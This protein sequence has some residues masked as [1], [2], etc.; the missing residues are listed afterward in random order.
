LI[1]FGAVKQVSVPNGDPETGL[2]NLTI[3]IGTQG[4]MANEQ[5][6]GKPKFCSDV[7]AVGVLAVQVLTG[8]HP[9]HWHED[10]N[11]E[12]A[13]H[14]QV[15]QIDPEFQAVLDRMIR[16]DFR[17][18]YIDAA[19]ALAALEALPE[20]TPDPEPDYGLLPETIRLN[21]SSNTAPQSATTPQTNTETSLSG[22][23][24]KANIE[25]SNGREVISSDE[26]PISTAIWVPNDSLIHALQNDKSGLTQ[27]VGRPLL[28]DSNS[29]SSG[30]PTGSSRYQTR[31]WFI[32]G[33]LLAAGL[34]VGLSQILFPQF[35]IQIGQNS[36][37]PNFT[38]HSTASPTPVLDPEQQAVLVLGEANHLLQTKQYDKALKAYARAIE[39]KSN[40]AEAYAGRCEAL[41]QLNRPEEAIVSCND[42]LDLKPNY[43]EALWSQGNVRLLQNRPYEALK[44]YEQVT[45][46]KPEF[47]AGWVK[48]GVALQRLGRSAEALDALDQGIDLERNSFE[49]WI[50]KGEALLNLQRYDPALAA[51]DKALQLQPND[52][53][54]IKLR[55]QVKAKAKAKAN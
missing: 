50:T 17:E 12:I 44:L 21:S 46:L 38:G 10:E 22:Q 15:S 23:L 19:E 36:A 53:Q 13:W 42:A 18:R 41:N 27:A 9:R 16:Y 34:L 25:F 54:A 51:I 29:T 37:I 26:E 7:Y 33:G 31:G 8:M 55:Q 35:R 28:P 30:K 47:A 39:L 5:L 40:Y 20:L 32:A 11:G 1:D 14:D 6:A 43:P 2:T 4:Y 48:R 45:D 24:A 49:A 3:S 52:P